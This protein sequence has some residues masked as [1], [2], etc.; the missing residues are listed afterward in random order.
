VERVKAKERKRKGYKRKWQLK[1]K[2]IR[3]RLDKG[4]VERDGS[5]GKSEGIVSIDSSA[6]KVRRQDF[7][8]ILPIPFSER[9]FMF[10]RQ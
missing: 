10:P 9:P 1:G 2:N 7:Q 5:E 8:L 4:T 3:I 6:V